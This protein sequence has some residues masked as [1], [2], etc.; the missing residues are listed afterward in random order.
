MAHRCDGL[1]DE[2]SWMRDETSILHA[3]N[4]VRVLWLL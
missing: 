1:E 2:K 3:N 4:T